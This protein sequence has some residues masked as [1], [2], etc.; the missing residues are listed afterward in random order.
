MRARRLRFPEAIR[1][2]RVEELTK[3]DL[4][5]IQGH[6]AL[7]ELK[8]SAY[9]AVWKVVKKLLDQKQALGFCAAS[10]SCENFTGGK[11]RS[12]ASC[13]AHARE[14]RLNAKPNLNRVLTGYEKWIRQKREKAR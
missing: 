8:E 1:N 9:K 10:L 3:K 7:F 6:V 14:L 2:K 4:K 11:T 13:R 5:L 12:C